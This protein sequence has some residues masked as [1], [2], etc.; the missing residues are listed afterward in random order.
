MNKLFKHI[1]LLLFITFVFNLDFPVPQESP[2]PVSPTHLHS[3]FQALGGCISSLLHAYPDGWS[4]DILLTPE[5]MKQRSNPDLDVDGYNN[6]WAVWD[7]AT[8]VSGTAE[9]L[10]SKRDSLGDCLI[11]ETDVSNNPSFSLLPRVVVDTSN[12]VH[13]IWRDQ[14]PQGM[15]LWHARLANDGSVIVP[16]HLAVNGAGGLGI[17]IEIALDK[18]QHI[19]SAWAESPFGYNQ[20][21]Y[22]KLDTLGNPIIEKI[23][24]SP[25]GLDAYWV[26]IGVDSMANNHL[27][28]RTDSGG[29][30]NRL[31]Y[32]KLDKDGNILISNKVLA[33]G[34]NNSIVSDK[35][36]N[37]HIVYTNPAGPGNRIDY[38][39]LDQNGNILIGPKTISSPQIH[40]NTY[41]HMAIDSLQYLHVV[42]Q[43]DSLAVVVYIMYCKLDTLGNYVIPPM[44][45]VYPPHTPGGGMPRIAVDHSNRLHVVWVDGRLNPGVT[46]DIFYKRGENETGVKE[47]ER[48]KSSILPRISVSPNPFFNET[49]ITFL[50]PKELKKCRIEIFDIIGRKVKEFI[51]DKLE[52]FITWQGTD[53]DGNYLPAGVYFIQFSTNI[54]DTPSIPIILLR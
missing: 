35:N 23:R 46:T 34:G 28:C 11:T 52:G 12:N 3:I 40:S 32:S 19:N 6:I 5:D 36:Q 21:S 45:I 7:S 20:M 33:T 26:G 41:A 44:K 47:I 9:I 16:S 8:W 29:I 24:V 50:L 37:I 48:S 42:W 17:S 15:G 25:E 1:L 10:Y 39:K 13:F 49:K 54:K 51:L 31:T 14:T 18:Y 4:D 2:L 27:A 30:T 53:N 43:G 38:L 22:T